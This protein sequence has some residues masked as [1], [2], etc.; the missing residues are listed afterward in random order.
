MSTAISEDVVRALASARGGAAAGAAGGGL[1]SALGSLLE[2]LSYPQQAAYWLVNRLADPFRPEGDYSPDMG[3][4]ELARALDADSLVGRAIVS[5]L[6][7]PLTFLGGGAGRLAGR[8]AGRQVAAVDGAMSDLRPLARQYEA[9]QAVAPEIQAGVDRLGA[10]RSEARAAGSAAEDAWRAAAGDAEAAY[11][12]QLADAQA[13][14]AWRLGDFAMQ[15]EEAV[16]ALADPASE[17]R[18]AIGG[19]RVPGVFAPPGGAKVGGLLDALAEYGYAHPL[20]GGRYAVAYGGLPAVRR[21]G[22]SLGLTGVPEESLADLPPGPFFPLRN[23]EPFAPPPRPTPPPRP[24][25]EEP[26]LSVR[27][28]LFD[29]PGATAPGSGRGLSDALSAMAPGLDPGDALMMPIDQ[30]AAA[31]ADRGRFIQAAARQAGDK[32]D[33]LPAFGRWFARTYGGG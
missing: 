17:L 19:G 32:I 13:A 23:P 33:A 1:L 8:S 30:A 26:T 7:D 12:R 2:P 10:L 14:R 28:V 4:D 29:S 31:M 20:D 11:A 5:T 27:D 6:T 25:V 24:R 16:A 22:N 3:P 9:M 18:A 15:P 21:R